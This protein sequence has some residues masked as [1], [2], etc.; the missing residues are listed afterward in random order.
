MFEI[1]FTT[2]YEKKAKKFFKKH[3]DLKQ[4]YKKTIF[5]LKS[6][7]FHPSLRLHK[8]KGSLSEYHSVSIDME[9]RIILDFIIIDEKIILIDIG[10]HDEVY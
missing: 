6:N 3:Q 4:K 9:Y 8:L 1:V 2:K 5:L 10:S 7:H